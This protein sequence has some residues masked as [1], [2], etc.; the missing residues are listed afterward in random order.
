MRLA[1]MGVC[2]K[3]WLHTGNFGEW[4]PGSWKMAVCRNKKMATCRNFAGKNGWIKE[5]M[6][7]CKKFLGEQI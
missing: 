4:P 1:K 2:R 3:K 5:K 7:V 6:A